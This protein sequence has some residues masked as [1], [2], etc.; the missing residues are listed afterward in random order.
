MQ[1]RAGG[2]VGKNKQRGTEEEVN[3]GKEEGGSGEM[4][5]GAARIRW[6]MPSPQEGHHEIRGAICA[7]SRIF[8]FYRNY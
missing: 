8:S 2:G 6:V 5:S 3:E 1:L 7:R 4:E